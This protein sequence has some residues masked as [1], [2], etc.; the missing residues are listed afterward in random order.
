LTSISLKIAVY[1]PEMSTWRMFAKDI[2]SD[3]IAK[4]SGGGGI[5]F[6]ILS[7]IFPKLLVTPWP[8]VALGVVCFFI[9]TFR[10]WFVAYSRTVPR[11]EL[12]PDH[13]ERRD[14]FHTQQSGFASEYHRIIVNNTG[15]E[16]IDDIRVF[17]ESFANMDRVIDL[18]PTGTDGSEPVC[19]YHEV[20]RAFD[21]FVYDGPGE[22]IHLIGRRD[23]PH[24][25]SVIPSERFEI[26]FSV[27]GK[28]VATKHYSV[29]VTPTPGDITTSIPVERPSHHGT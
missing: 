3:A 25:Q 16:P 22:C 10:A 17:M 19:L 29:W 6:G 21:L 1:D 8:F 26:R 27:A 24:I 12:V 13:S 11:F 18:I 7:L 5:I 4:W 9:S 28:G 15:V 2:A 23:Q 20:L 14:R